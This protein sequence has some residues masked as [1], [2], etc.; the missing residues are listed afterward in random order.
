MPYKD[1]FTLKCS[2]EDKNGKVFDSWEEEFPNEQVAGKLFGRLLMISNNYDF[3][4]DPNW[5]GGS[6]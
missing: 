3:C 5:D 6:Q 1:P 4:F 2:Y